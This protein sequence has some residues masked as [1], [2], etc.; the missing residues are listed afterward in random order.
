MVFFCNFKTSLL[1]CIKLQDSNAFLV[2]LNGYLKK[3]KDVYILEN[4]SRLKF[5]VFSFEHSMEIVKID[6]CKTFGVN[7]A[8]N[9]IIT[10]SKSNKVIGWQRQLV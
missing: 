9:T 3:I 2:K 8:L 6:F 1:K 5:N 7:N 4:P 10:C